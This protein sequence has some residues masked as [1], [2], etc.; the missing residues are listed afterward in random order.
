[1]NPSTKHIKKTHIKQCVLM[2]QKKKLEQQNNSQSKASCITQ[3]VPG[4]P[5]RG[6]KKKMSG[7]IMTLSDE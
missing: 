5:K 3:N 1:M 7:R 2:R 4:L 6:S